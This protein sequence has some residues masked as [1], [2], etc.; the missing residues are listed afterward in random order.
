MSTYPVEHD[1][2]LLELYREAAKAE[3]NRLWAIGTLQHQSRPKGTW[4]HQDR[5]SLKEVLAAHEELRTGENMAWHQQDLDKAIEKYNITT[6]VLRAIEGRIAEHEMGYAGWSRFFLVTSSSGL[7]HSSMHCSTCNK[8][9]K[10]TQFALLPSFS[11]RPV[12]GLVDLVGPALCSVCFSSAPTEWTDAVR[13]PGRIAEY[14]L[15]LG[16]DEFRSELKTYK[17]NQAAKAAK[18]GS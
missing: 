6:A 9:R 16:E 18:K 7:V 11:G 5:R 14:L 3:Q 12:D 15:T 1:T 17:A 13:I 10:A 8:G 2:R 4:S